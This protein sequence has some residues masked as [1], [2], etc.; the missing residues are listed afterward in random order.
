MTAFLDVTGA[1]LL[2]LGCL[3]SLV[4]GIGLV[5]FPD[6]LTRMHAATKPQ[7]LGL[8][9]VAGGLALV[10]RD[11][12]TTLLLGLVVVA[13]LMT[14]P[15]A[16][17]MVARASWRGGQVRHDLLSVDE[18]TGSPVLDEDRGAP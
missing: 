18:L 5:R 15:V 13:Q 9:L 14:I 1:V 17:H 4:A 11:V 12:S 8:L 7:V 10:L 6:L 2:L 16:S 3:L